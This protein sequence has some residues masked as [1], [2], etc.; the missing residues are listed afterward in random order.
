MLLLNKKFLYRNDDDDNKDDDDSD[1]HDV[2]ELVFLVVAV[3]QICT[4]L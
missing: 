3:L 2:F 1:D 4:L